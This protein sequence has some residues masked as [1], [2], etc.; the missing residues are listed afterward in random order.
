MDEG[1]DTLTYR[2]P[3][4]NENDYQDN[5]PGPLHAFNVFVSLRFPAKTLVRLADVVNIVP[6]AFWAAA[7]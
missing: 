3:N 7:P 2:R 6:P 1:G 5:N 4:N